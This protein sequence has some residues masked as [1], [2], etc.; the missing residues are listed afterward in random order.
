[1]GYRDYKQLGNRK[2]K[3]AQRLNLPVFIPSYQ[4]PL[5]FLQIFV[6][7]YLLIKAL[8]EQNY[9]EVSNITQPDDEA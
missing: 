5:Q 7:F 2:R 8:K 3:F 9:V 4:S 1:M 6:D